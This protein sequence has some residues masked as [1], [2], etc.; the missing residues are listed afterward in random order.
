MFGLMTVSLTSFSQIKGKVVDQTTKE[1]LANDAGGSAVGTLGAGF[2]GWG[3]TSD[4]S[5]KINF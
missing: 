2:K 5:L 4:V 3:R 1:V